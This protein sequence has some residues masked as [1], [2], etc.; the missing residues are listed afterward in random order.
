[1]DPSYYERINSA[2]GRLE[3]NTP[4]LKFYQEQCRAMVE[5][6]VRVRDSLTIG[7]NV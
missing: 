3:D 1:M 7:P 2:I 6:F 4:N 5:E